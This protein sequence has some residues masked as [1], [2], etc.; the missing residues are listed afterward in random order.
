MGKGDEECESMSIRGRRTG[1]EMGLGEK[2][3]KGG[4]PRQ[5]LRSSFLVFNFV[6]GPDCSLDVFNADEAF[7][8]GKIVSNRVFPCSRVFSTW[9]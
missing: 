1:L 7:V 4:L 9:E 8:E 5:F 3:R 6:D 2:G